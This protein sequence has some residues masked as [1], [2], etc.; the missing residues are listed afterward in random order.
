MGEVGAKINFLL[1]L[2]LS[3]VRVPFDD[4]NESD[5]PLSREQTDARR[6]FGSEYL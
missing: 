5:V 3:L 1:L 6:F 4:K 2:L